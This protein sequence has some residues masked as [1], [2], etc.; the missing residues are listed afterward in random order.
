MY[1]E[2]QL[3]LL[4]EKYGADHLRPASVSCAFDA[5]TPDVGDITC[6]FTASGSADHSIG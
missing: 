3:V 6:S 4:R 2:Q 5:A 1:I